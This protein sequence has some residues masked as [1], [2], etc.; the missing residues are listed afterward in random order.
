VSAVDVARIRAALT[1]DKP[2][3]VCHKRNGN[4]HCP[5]HEDANPS[6]SVTTENGKVLVHCNA[7]C[8]QDSIVTALKDRKLWPSMIVAEYDYVD[9]KGKLLFQTVRF[10]PKDFR[11]RQPDGKGGWQWNLNGVRRIPYRLNELIATKNRKRE[12]VWLVEGEKDADLLSH[13]GHAATTTPMG[14]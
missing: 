14:G 1:C 6:L 7:G 12:W 9:E 2:G 11:Q 4:S 10:E 8:E 13:Y 5:S 3:C